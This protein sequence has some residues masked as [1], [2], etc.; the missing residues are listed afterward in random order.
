MGDA[1]SA[2]L[3]DG[4]EQTAHAVVAVDVHAVIDVGRRDKT[5]GYMA[6]QASEGRTSVD[7]FHIA[8]K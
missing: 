1:E 8:R 2:S 3:G 7:T 4:A 5:V 6:D